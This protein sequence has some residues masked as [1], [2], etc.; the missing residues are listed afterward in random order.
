MKGSMTISKAITIAGLGCLGVIAAMQTGAQG[1]ATMTGKALP[2]FS[3]KSLSG[4]KVSNATLKGKVVLLDF[5]ATWC[6]PCVK[7]S[8]TMQK[9]HTKYNKKGL[10]VIGMNLE[11]GTEDSDKAKAM[12]YVKKH[13]YTYLNTIGNDGLASKLQVS[14][15]PRFV[16]VD[17]KGKIIGDWTGSSDG[18]EKAVTP[19]IEKAL[20]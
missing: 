9:L 14:G 7:M 12:D 19:L 8:P 18:F 16:L 5:W 10:V 13:K 1:G 2:T 4:A 17:K 11:G 20:K 15:I 6:G 3:A